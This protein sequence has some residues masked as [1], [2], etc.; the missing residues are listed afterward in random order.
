MILNITIMINIKIKYSCYECENA[1]KDSIMISRMD[2]GDRS[3]VFI[4]AGNKPGRR[5]GM[6]I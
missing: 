3:A 6:S 2:T 4:S 5:A 1:A